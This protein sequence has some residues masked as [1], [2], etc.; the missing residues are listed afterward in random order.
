M[1]G[2]REKAGRCKTRRETTQEIRPADTFWDFQLLEQW[3]IKF[4]LFKPPS[5]WY[6]VMAPLTQD[7]YKIIQEPIT[8]TVSKD[9]RLSGPPSL[10]PKIR[11]KNVCSPN[12]VWIGIWRGESVI[13]QDNSIDLIHPLTSTPST[14]PTPTP[15]PKYTHTDTNHAYY[16]NVLFKT[17]FHPNYQN[18]CF[19]SLWM[20]ICHLGHNEKKEK[21]IKLTARL[22]GLQK[23]IFLK[24]K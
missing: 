6:S 23:E 21:G 9:E 12:L 4:L 16:L 2:H 11:N 7:T 5:L 19:N 18:S 1:W 17:N 14:R 8:N 13:Y 15:T 20:D 3:E 22:W 10:Q 24:K